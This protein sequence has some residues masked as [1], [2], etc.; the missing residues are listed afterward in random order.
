MK[1]NHILQLNQIQNQTEMKI[2]YELIINQFGQ[3]IFD[4][5]YMLDFFDK[6]IFDEKKEILEGII[7]LIIQ[8]KCNPDDI[9]DAI[10][11]SMLKET[12]TPCVMLK[13]GINQSNLFRI[14]DLPKDEMT[15]SFILF[16]SL[17]KI[18]YRKRLDLERGKSNKWWYK[19]LSNEKIIKDVLSS[20]LG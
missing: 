20:G 19:D 15:K 12:F 6:L 3:N 9:D 10:R 8:S 7:F 14:I 1:P 13:K 4:K 17:F 16:L 5:D 18:S 2:E 11:L